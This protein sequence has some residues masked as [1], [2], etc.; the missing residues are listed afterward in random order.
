MDSLR[1]FVS[2]VLLKPYCDF[3]IFCKF[4]VSKLM[5]IFV[6]KIKITSNNYYKDDLVRLSNKILLHIIIFTLVFEC[7]ILSSNR[8]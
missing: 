3:D 7:Y 8:G 6:C 5:S 1:R 2:I 4:T